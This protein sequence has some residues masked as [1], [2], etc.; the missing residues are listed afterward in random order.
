MGEVTSAI[1]LEAEYTELNEEISRSLRR[2]A[3]EVVRLGYL[4]RRMMEKGLYRVYYADFDSYLREELHMDYTLANRFMGVNKKYSIGG[5]SEHIAEGYREYSQGLLVE[6]LSMSPELEE[7]V[8]P[9]MTVKQV[10]EIKRQDRQK[11]V[12]MK[13]AVKGLL[14]KWFSCAV[15]GGTLVEEEQPEKCP[16][17]GQM[18]D[19]SGYTGAEIIDG[20]YTELEGEKNVA[21]SQS[22]GEGDD[23]CWFV[24]QYV[25]LEPGESAKLIEICRR[26]KNN[27][28]RAK[29]IQKQIA[30]YGHHYT[31]CS[32]YCFEFQGFAKGIDLRVGCDGI[33]LTYIRFASELT[34]IGEYRV[35]MSQPEKSAY[36]L[37]RTEYPEESLITTAGCG[38]KHACF[39]CAQDCNIRQE[40]RYCVLA[41]MGNPFHCTTMS[42]L[43]NLQEEVGDRCQFVNNDL[44]YHRAGDGEADPCCRECKELC[45]YRCQRAPL[46][47]ES[48]EDDT[49]AE[50]TV[51]QEK[52]SDEMKILKD[53]LAEAKQLLKDYMDSD[54]TPE[55]MV[56]RQKLQVGALANMVCELEII[57]GK[58]APQQELPVLKN[59]DQRKQWLNDYKSWGLWYQDE[60]IDVNYYKFD[61]ADGS[62]LIA[63]EYPQRYAYWSKE[64]KDEA[65]YHLLEKNKKG[66]DHEYDEE[67]RQQTDSET[68]LVEFL[69]KIQKKG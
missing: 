18:Q 55:T 5:D 6:M 44:A 60:N 40:D 63:A 51:E 41:P 47:E 54:G 27:S 62:R 48:D 45:G 67:Y 53:M 22:G 39:S 1:R 56:H 52:D 24:E 29:A 58:K 30:S 11:S 43:D 20:E 13:P 9:D 23:E 4:L 42:I 15:C 33:H 34:K 3:A 50:N 49:E 21:T 36:G 59:N 25:K 7:K 35:A 38:H 66:Y 28:D 61:F 57:Q 12:K 32:E 10:R 65:Y 2:S 64:R 17:C 26:E 37:E 14:S 16:K 68:Y 31:A 8:R 46:Q 69:K 19:W